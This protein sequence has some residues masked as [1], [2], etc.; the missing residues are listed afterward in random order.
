MNALWRARHIDQT[1]V[2]I[3]LNITTMRCGYAWR[4]A[5]ASKSSPAAFSTYKSSPS[6]ILYTFLGFCL[7]STLTAALNLPVD[8]QITARL[9]DSYFPK[10][11]TP[12]E[13][14]KAIEELK[15]IFSDKNQVLTSVDV[16]E[17][18]GNSPNFYLHG[19]P[20]SVVVKI[21]STDDVVKVVK[22][23]KKWRMPVT[24]W[25][26]GTSLEG[27]FS[28]VSKAISFLNRVL[29]LKGPSQ[30]VIDDAPGGICIDLSGMNKVIQIN[31][32]PRVYGDIE[33]ATMSNHFQRT[34]PIL[35]FR[36][37][38]NGKR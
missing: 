15:H 12:R 3:G 27:H 16:L 33:V 28:G 5:I 2:V 9:F 13:V 10:Y 6:L 38:S 1:R 14:Q 29:V 20:H 17:S 19:A 22:V 36:V 8:R 30:T 37:V 7:G 35:L 32:E 26:G 25:S 23:A 34:I 11:A 18:Y 4:R 24:A 31:G 21:F